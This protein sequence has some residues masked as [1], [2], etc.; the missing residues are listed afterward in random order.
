[1]EG[2]D[3]S[4]E[5]LGLSSDGEGRG[6][7]VTRSRAWLAE[8]SQARGTENKRKL[9]VRDSRSQIAGGSLS[10]KEA[11]SPLQV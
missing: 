6:G 2:G 3:K 1:M 4:L 7:G 8:A 9:R 10:P 11:R 5:F